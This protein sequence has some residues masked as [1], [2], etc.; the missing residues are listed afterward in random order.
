MYR[1]SRCFLH[2]EAEK[3]FYRQNVTQN[4]NQ[5]PWR[6]WKKSL[7]PNFWPPRFQPLLHFHLLWPLTKPQVSLGYVL[8]RHEKRCPRPLQN[9][10]FLS[11]IRLQPCLALREIVYD[12]LGKLCTE[13]RRTRE[14]QQPSHHEHFLKH[15]LRPLLCSYFLIE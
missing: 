10:A 11:L 5:M 1:P 3:P 12:Y 14:R 4:G 2:F 9:F 15:S 6:V 13:R 7:W 8:W